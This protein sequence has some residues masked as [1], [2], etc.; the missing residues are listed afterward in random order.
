MSY[1][2]LRL[3]YLYIKMKKLLFT[4][5]MAAVCA[6]SVSAQEKQENEKGGCPKFYLGV[7]TGLENPAGLLGVNID[8]PI[9][10]ASIGGGLGLSSWG[11]KA[12]VEGRYY[13]DPCNRGLAFGIGASHSTGLSDFTLKNA[14]TNIG[15]QDINMDLNPVTNIYFSTYYFFNLGKAGRSR[16]Y[17]Q[18]GYS[19]RLT[20]DIYTMKSPFY[21]NTNGERAMKM[22]APGGLIIALGFSFALGK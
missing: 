7:S 21:F 19:A 4:L 9:H 16:F 22:A 20:D 2:Y 13:V 14:E 17:L 6:T 5:S 18:G 12:Y 10:N 3:N 8:V 11:M 15:K 1:I